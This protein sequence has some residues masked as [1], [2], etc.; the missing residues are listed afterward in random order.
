MSIDWVTVIAQAAN[1][2]ILV[3]LLK[4]FLYA[5]VIAA[6]D[7]REQRVQDRLESARQREQAA[8]EQAKSHEDALAQI[9]A[10]RQAREQSARE[11]A[12]QTRQRLID[13][14]REQVSA[15]RAQWRQ[16]LQQDKQSLQQTLRREALDCVITVSDRLLADLAETT[17]KDAVVQ[18]FVH[19]LETNTQAGAD[20]EAGSGDWLDKGLDTNASL[21]VISSFSLSDEQKTC[22]STTLEKRLGSALDLA[23]KVDDDLGLG[24]A[25]EANGQRISWSSHGFFEILD[26]RIDAVVNDTGRS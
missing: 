6:M 16:A 23:F 12:E 2:L 24:L 13:E 10:E 4:R 26:K 19:Q 8:E 20:T 7:R 14:A 5:P 3:Y 9:E 1:F 11:Q 21:Q 18:R 22:L 15:R 25:L 17:L